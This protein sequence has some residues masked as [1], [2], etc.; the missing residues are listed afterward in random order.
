MAHRNIDRIIISP[1]TAP[2]RTVV[3]LPTS[4]SISNRALIMAAL[5][6]SREG[7]IGLSDAGDTRTLDHLLTER[8]LRMD[9]GAGGTTLR[10]VLAWAS[11]Q[12]NEERIITGTPR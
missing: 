7:L 1:P 9:C 2:I 8:P 4:K 12:E 11:I 5:S 10:F 6:G 3:Q